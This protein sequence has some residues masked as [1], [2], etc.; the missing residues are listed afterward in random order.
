V[1][2]FDGVPMDLKVALLNCLLVWFFFFVGLYWMM[3][4]Q[5]T[6]VEVTACNCWMSWNF[7]EVVV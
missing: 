3:E 1:L 2:H 6:K 5:F 7:L 4:N